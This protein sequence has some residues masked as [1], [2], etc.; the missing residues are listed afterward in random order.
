MP[1]S[2]RFFALNRPRA[3]A[4]LLLV[5]LLWGT[6]FVA[7]KLGGTNVGPLAFVSVRF[8]AATL[9]LIPFALWEARH[10]TT[11]IRRGDLAGGVAIGAC[12][13]AAALLQQTAM[14]STS[15]TNAGFL[16]AVYMVLVP[17][18]AW[19]V[20]RRAPRPMVLLAC[21]VALYGAWLL[22]GSS[23]GQQWSRGDVLVLISDLIWALHITLIAQFRGI[24]GRPML[25]STLQCAI[26]GIV[27]L[28]FAFVWQPVSLNDVV[29]GLPA[30]L[31]AGIISS[32]IAFTFQIVAQRHT[33]PA[34]AALI[35]SLESVFAAVA[36][37]IF[38]GE[39][40]TLRAAIGAFL[41]MLGVVMVETGPLLLAAVGQVFTRKG[42]APAGGSLRD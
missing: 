23:A 38:L 24:A 37:A 28:P 7:Q 15:A 8:L 32:G 25:L 42:R 41:I 9:F 19:L 31:Y 4:L 34:E 2:S 20:T 27:A 26:T 35:M 5:A 40:L 18:V 14:T 29:S 16:T 22:A 21:A 17:F 36:G 10:A 3:D 1:F 6:T 13:C 11:G 12:L 30:I 39:M 33:P